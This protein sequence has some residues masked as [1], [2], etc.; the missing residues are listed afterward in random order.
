MITFRKIRDRIL[1]ALPHRWAGWLRSW[2]MRRSLKTFQSRWVT[3]NYGSDTF[4]V[5]I[6]DGLGQGWYDNDWDE[7]PE[8]VVSRLA[9]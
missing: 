7:L 4:T 8:S 6:E 1:H 5:R 9:R 3:H 2:K